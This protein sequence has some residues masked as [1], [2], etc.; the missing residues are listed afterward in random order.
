MTID[1]RAR[2]VRYLRWWSDQVPESAGTLLLRTL[3]LSIESGD[4]LT[5]Y[6]AIVTAMRKGGF[7]WDPRGDA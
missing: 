5:D 3:A 2:I 1:E 6:E 7:T 4:H